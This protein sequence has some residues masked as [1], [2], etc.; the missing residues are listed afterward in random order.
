MLRTTD[1]FFDDAKLPHLATATD[2]IKMAARFADKFQ[3]LLVERNWQV[4]NCA[5]ERIQYRRGRRCRLLY[6]INL[7]DHR[8][9]KIDQWFYGKLLRH[10]QAQRQYEEAL[11]AGNLQNGVWLPVRLWPDLE[12][13]VWTFPN[14]PDMPG[15]IKAANPDFVRAQINAQRAALGLPENFQ[16]VEASCERVKYMPGK[17]CV[18]R[19]AA[20]LAARSGES[21]M[22]SFYSK[23]YCDGMSRFH[24]QILQQVYARLGNAIDIPRPLLHVD[25]ANTLW[26]ASWEGRPLINMLDQADWEELFPRL[27]QSAA[28]FHQSRCEGLPPVDVIERAFNSAQ[29]DAQMLGWLLPQYHSRFGA[30]LTKLAAA[31]EIL[32]EQQVPNVPTHGAIRVEQFVARERDLALVD[33]DAAALGDPLYDVAEF[34]TSLQYLEFTAGFSRQRLAQAAALF[35]TSYAQQAPW[36]LSPPRV[37][38]YAVSALLSKMHDTMKN[39]DAKAM[40]QF[41]EIWKILD[42]WIDGMME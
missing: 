30:V 23:T 24:Y 18:L 11:N 32:A 4:E 25:E 6:R 5:I 31:K 15:L 19:Y 38:F 12:M 20:Q 26:Q 16:C 33:F 35:K 17:R 40:Q 28:S 41:D 39:L 29:E 1:N 21:R 9:Q 34:L 42:G 14:D 10:G 8:G 7:R 2:P 3:P 22:F 37:A 27:A 13:V 36:K